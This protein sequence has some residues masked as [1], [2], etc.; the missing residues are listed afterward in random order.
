M[1]NTNASL[2]NDS[3]QLTTIERSES[4]DKPLMII[5][6]PLGM[7]GPRLGDDEK[8]KKEEVK[9]NKLFNHCKSCCK[10]L[11][12]NVISI[13]EE[14]KDNLICKKCGFHPKTYQQL[15]NHINRR[16]NPCDYYKSMKFKCVACQF[17]T[18]YE[19]Y[20]NLHTLTEKHKK[21]IIKQ[22]NPKNEIEIEIENLF[23]KKYGNPEL[24]GNKVICNFCMKKIG[25]WCYNKHYN[26]CSKFNTYLFTNENNEKGYYCKEC[27]YF[28]TT[29]WN[30][31][32]HFKRSHN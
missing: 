9:E 12:N 29:P 32:R 6:K 14:C 2:T 21:R 16:N 30:F 18:N 7:M 22:T 10:L 23:K 1:G 11:L 26:F 20:F 4:I 28:T 19:Y 13:C 24:I 15:E 8:I 5:D 3:T 27:Q 31:T 17:G 25:K